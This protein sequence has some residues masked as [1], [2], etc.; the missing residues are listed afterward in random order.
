MW[1][2]NNLANLDA[3]GTMNDTDENSKIPNKEVIKSIPKKK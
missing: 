2:V 1:N 3:N